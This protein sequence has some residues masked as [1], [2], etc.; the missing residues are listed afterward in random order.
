MRAAG[1]GAGGGVRSTKELE[2]GRQDAGEGGT[3]KWESQGMRSWKETRHALQ[4]KWETWARERQGK[5]GRPREMGT[6][7]TSQEGKRRNLRK[8]RDR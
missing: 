1:V 5:P 4:S 8:Q 7:V 3:L 2:E 6:R